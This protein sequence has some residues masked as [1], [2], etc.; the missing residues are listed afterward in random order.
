VSW[1]VFVMRVPAQIENMDD[2]P[3]D[4]RPEP[5]GTV[6]SVRAAIGAVV[7]AGEGPGFSLDV[8]L[9][10]A[11]SGVVPSMMLNFYGGG[12]AAHAAIAIADRLGA[13]AMDGANGFLELDTATD[14]YQAWQRY[15]DQIARDG[16]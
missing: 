2:I 7:P 3:V 12:S 10:G 1:D 5:L 8:H 11:D 9:D 13:R 4:F 6:E 15:R 16:A 14:S